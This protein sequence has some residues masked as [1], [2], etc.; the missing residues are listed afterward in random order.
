M[1]PV[2]LF[3]WSLIHLRSGW[4]SVGLWGHIR[5]RGVE[6]PWK[7][8]EKQYKTEDLHPIRRHCVQW[9]I[10]SNTVK[11]LRMEDF[12]D[13]KMTIC[14]DIWICNPPACRRVLWI[15]LVRSCTVCLVFC[16][17]LDFPLGADFC[18]VELQPTPPPPLLRRHRPLRAVRLHLLPRCA[19]LNSAHDSLNARLVLNM[20]A[21]IAVVFVRLF[22]CVCHRFAVSC[23]LSN[24][25][26][27]ITFLHMAFSQNPSLCTHAS[28]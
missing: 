19:G 9:S 7:L 22:G 6:T 10:N 16:L 15:L 4:I 25:C 3:G 24:T 20:F 28:A 21:V 26:T 14:M 11:L 12:F 17:C 27:C 23:H 5:W 13:M 1:F 8:F 2:V 18:L